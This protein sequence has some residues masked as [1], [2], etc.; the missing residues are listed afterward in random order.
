MNF[1]VLIHYYQSEHSR[2]S[3]VEKAWAWNA[4]LQNAFMSAILTPVVI[5]SLP[6]KYEVLLAVLLS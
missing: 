6:N 4:H 3:I 2:C 1:N 5:G